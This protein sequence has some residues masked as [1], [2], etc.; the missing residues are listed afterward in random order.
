M[1]KNN[2]DNIKIKFTKIKDERNKI[3]DLFIKLQKLKNNIKENYLHYIQKE[4]SDFYGLDSFHFQN[5]VIKLEFENMMRLYQFIDNRI[6]GDYYKLFVQIYNFLKKTL[7]RK[8]YEKI[9]E[10]D[11]V[12]KYPVYKDLNQFKTY[13]F[14]T[15]NN[16]H[17][18]IIIVTMTVKD[19]YKENELSINEDMK[20]M[21]TGMNIDNYIINNQYK[22]MNLI[23]TNTKFQNYLQ[24]YHKYHYDLLIKFYEKLSLVYRQILLSNKQIRNNEEKYEMTVTP[25]HKNTEYTFERDI[26]SSSDSESSSDDNAIVSKFQNDIIENSDSS[27]E[28]VNID[29][30]P[31]KSEDIG[32]RDKIDKMNKK[33][34]ILKKE[35]EEDDE[36]SK[37]IKEILNDIVTDVVD[38]SDST[39]D[40]ENILNEIESN[41]N[42]KA[43]KKN[44]RG[45]RNEQKR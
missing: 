6:Y 16:I 45:K 32:L 22:N 23:T 5:K 25:S 24:V 7:T 37:M 44:V 12:P 15:I 43:K 18:D 21:M 36:S 13:D 8:Q 27:D 10:L 28:G 30:Q 31:D 33:D 20:K 29:I 1:D 34:N 26:L 40:H 38:H 9:K 17:Q 39:S 14:D 3:R 4:K 42:Q 2:T 41:D 35:N 19:I 11:N